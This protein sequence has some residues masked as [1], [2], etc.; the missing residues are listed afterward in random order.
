VSHVAL[1]QCLIGLAEHNGFN[2]PDPMAIDIN[3]NGFDVYNAYTMP[4]MPKD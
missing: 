1:A 2:V 3:E 4:K